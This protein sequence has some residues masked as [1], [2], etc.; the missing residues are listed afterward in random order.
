M[1]TQSIIVIGATSGIGEALAREAHQRGYRVGITGRREHRLQSIKQELEERCW[2]Q[3]M[4]VKNLSECRQQFHALTNRMQGCDILVINAG[5]ASFTRELSHEN[6]HHV[7]DVNVRGFVDLMVT[8]FDYFQKQGHGHLV[9]VSSIA[10]MFGYGLSTAYS[11]SKAFAINYLQGFRQKAR[12]SEADITVTDIRPGYVKSEMTEDKR[13]MFW[14]AESEIAAH[15]M[16]DAIERKQHYAFITRRWRLIAWLIRWL[17][18]RLF[19]HI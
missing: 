13:G 10:G 6:E 4:D 5:V 12:R 11:A 2:I 15:Q 14:V 1:S 19:D 18:N 7:I 3:P 16:M 8:G 9:G 17:P